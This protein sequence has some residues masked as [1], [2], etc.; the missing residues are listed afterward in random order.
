MVNILAL[1]AINKKLA[2]EVMRKVSEIL[3]LGRS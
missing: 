1:Q 2:D 3:M